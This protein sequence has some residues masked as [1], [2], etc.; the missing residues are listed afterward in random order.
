[1]TL[2][3]TA[4][5]ISWTLLTPGPTNTLIALA[6]AER[7]W[8]RAL[9]PLIPAELAGY[10]LATV[11]LALL[12]ARLLETRPALKVGITLVAALWVLWPRGRDVAPARGW[13]RRA[14]RHAR[15]GSHH[16]ASQPKTL[17]FGGSCSCQRP[18]SRGRSRVS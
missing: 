13:P 18:R 10:L 11:P 3:E 8:M 14:D 4:L 17:V 1:M 16:D 5:I 12:G 15:G 6:G 2:I 9:P 7:G